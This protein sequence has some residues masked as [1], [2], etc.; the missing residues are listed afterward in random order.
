MR[1]VKYAPTGFAAVVEG[2]R[3]GVDRGWR[4]AA[5]RVTCV[6]RNFFT[7]AAVGDRHLHR[8]LGVRRRGGAR[9]N[10]AA[11]FGVGGY[12]RWGGEPVGSAGEGGGEHE[13]TY[14]E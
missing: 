7:R 4:D 3:F 6:L 1:F 9:T 8:G 10:R 5:Q 2:S 11:N 13:R 12:E 14:R